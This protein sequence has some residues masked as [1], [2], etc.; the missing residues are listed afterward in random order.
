[1]STYKLTPDGKVKISINIP[2]NTLKKLDEVRKKEKKTRSNWITQVILEK[3]SIT[4][5]KSS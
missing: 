4:L 3:F 2:L 5:E 1:M